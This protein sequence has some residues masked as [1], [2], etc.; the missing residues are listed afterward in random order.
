MKI[1][2]TKDEMKLICEFL[3][4]SSNNVDGNSKEKIYGAYW[5]FRTALSNSEKITELNLT[6]DEMRFMCTLM[7]GARSKKVNDLFMRIS[8][9]MQSYNLSLAT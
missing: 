3:K 7:F 1:L 2:F 6:K 5:K 8:D 9:T 4:N